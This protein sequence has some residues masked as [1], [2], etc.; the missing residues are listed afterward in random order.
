MNK[1]AQAQRKYP[2]DV[3][4]LTPAYSV[5]QVTVVKQSMAWSGT[6]YGDETESGKRYPAQDMH[7]TKAAAIAHGRQQIVARSEY[8]AKQEALLDKRLA[9]LHKAEAAA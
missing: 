8:L 6:D 5:K 1:K 4:V 9:K 2:R 3:W 7:A